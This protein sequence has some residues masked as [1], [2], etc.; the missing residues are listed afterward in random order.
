MF[1]NKDK[2]EIFDGEFLKGAEQEH[3]TCSCPLQS[4]VARVN[5]SIEKEEECYPLITPFLKQKSGKA[6]AKSLL[7]KD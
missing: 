5:D 6:T 1:F 3:A 2:G 4:T 7:R